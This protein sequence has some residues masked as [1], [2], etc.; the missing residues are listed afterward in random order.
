MTRM[1]ILRLMLVKVLRSFFKKIKNKNKKKE[2]QRERE[3][4]RER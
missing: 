4:E 2:R 1:I 3:R